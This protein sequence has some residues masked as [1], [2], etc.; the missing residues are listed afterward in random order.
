MTQTLGEK[1]YEWLKDEKHWAQRGFYFNKD[2]QQLQTV[3]LIKD[4]KR[5]KEVCSTCLVGAF[6]IKSDSFSMP[7]NYQAFVIGQT[8]YT[9]SIW[10]DKISTSHNDVLKLCEDIIAWEKGECKP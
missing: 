9:P 2:G 1:V 3:Y 7:Y 6:Y 4:K 10:N 5:I 8:N